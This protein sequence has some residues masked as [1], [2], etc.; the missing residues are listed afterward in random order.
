MGSED[1]FRVV[2]ARRPA[3]SDAAPPPA[4]LHAPTAHQAFLPLARAA[5]RGEHNHAA[6]A[7][8]KKE[9]YAALLPFLRQSPDPL[10]SRSFVGGAVN[11]L[12]PRLRRTAPGLAEADLRS[13]W[14]SGEGGRPRESSRHEQRPR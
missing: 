12:L 9:C 8:L 4:S 14:V 13:L 6:A 10:L 1:G 5:G 11:L 3:P 7:A 2:Q